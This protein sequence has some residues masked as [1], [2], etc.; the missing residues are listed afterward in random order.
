MTHESVE[1]ICSQLDQDLNN[2][3]YVQQVRINPHWYHILY[4]IVDK[5]NS[6]ISILEDPSVETYLIQ[7]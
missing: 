2:K 4:N 7:C 3:P 6:N 1:G 5:N